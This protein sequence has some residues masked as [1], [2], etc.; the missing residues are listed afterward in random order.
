MNCARCHAA[1]RVLDSRP[2][3]ADPGIIRRRRV[4]EGCGRRSVT[5]ES[6]LNPVRHRANARGA[7]QRWRAKLSP[8]ARAEKRR[9]HDLRY[10]AKR[11]AAETNTP[12]PEIMRAWD[13]TPTTPAP[14]RRSHLLP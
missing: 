8:E 3:D 6:T 11:Q 14:P 12:L 13:L 7:R 10:A 4:C 2:M 1:T 5:Y 9:L